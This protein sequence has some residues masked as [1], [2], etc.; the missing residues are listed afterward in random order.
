LPCQEMPGINGP[1]T[2]KDRR[3]L[4]VEK[5]FQVKTYD[6]D[7]AGHVSNIVYIRW[8][9]DLRFALLDAYFPLKPQLDAGYAPIL[10]RTNI[11]YRRAIRLFEP[12]QG[13]MWVQSVGGAKA[14]L[15]ARIVV[16]EDVCADVVQE[17]VFADLTTGRPMRIPD[18]FRKVYDTWQI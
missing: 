4:L 8:L 17:G 13:R 2:H 10:I 1:M 5:N 18:A 7:F 3:P 16:N 12:V 15:A 9:E 11:Q 14:L 6:I